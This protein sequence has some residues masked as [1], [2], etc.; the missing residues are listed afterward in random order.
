MDQVAAVEK[1]VRVLGVG[2]HGISRRFEMEAP[3]VEEV[4]P[5]L[6]LVG[7]VRKTPEALRE[8]CA[9]KTLVPFSPRM[10]GEEGHDG[11]DPARGLVGEAVETSPSFEARSAPLL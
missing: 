10:V 4:E 3:A 9:G 6:D 5:L 2:L 7:D 8:R 1:K 11:D